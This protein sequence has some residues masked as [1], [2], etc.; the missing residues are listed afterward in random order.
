MYIG[1]AR[2]GFFLG[3]HYFLPLL[4]FVV[5]EWCVSVLSLLEAMTS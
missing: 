3:G 5:L 2:L 1:D 4:K